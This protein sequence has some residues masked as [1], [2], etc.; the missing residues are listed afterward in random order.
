M[1]YFKYTIYSLVV[2]LA[3]I[4]GS[5]VKAVYPV[6]RRLRRLLQPGIGLMV[7]IVFTLFI[8]ATPA[9]GATEFV[10]V[11]DPAGGEGS[12]FS[13]LASWNTTVGCDLTA[14][15]TLVFTY[16]TSTVSG[17]IPN[18][19]EVTGATSGATSTAVHV[20]STTTPATH[21]ILMKE[22]GSGPFLNGEKVYIT[23]EGGGSSNYIYLSSTGTQAI[24]VA[25]CRNTGGSGTWDTSA[26]NLWSTYWTTDSDLYIKIWTDPDDDYSRHKGIWDDN[27]YKY[28]YT[29][30]GSWGGGFSIT[31]VD[32]EIEGLQ[33]ELNS[34]FNLSYHGI[35]EIGATINDFDHQ[36]SHNIIR[37]GSISTLT[38][39]GIY[40]HG[41]ANLKLF[42]NIIYGFN[43]TNSGAI[44][45]DSKASAGINTYVYNNTIYSNY[46]GIDLYNS[47]ASYNAAYNNL[48]ASNLADFYVGQS[49]WDDGSNNASTDG[50]ADFDPDFADYNN[51]YD[52]Q[53]FT[54]IDAT[55]KDFH[56]DP[57]DTGARQKGT[58]TVA[59]D[60]NMGL[61]DDIDGTPRSGAMDIGAD[62][63]ATEFI[64][65][66]CETSGSSGDC[67]E[68]DYSRLYDWEAAVDCDLT[69]SST[70]IF[71]GS[72]TGQLDE[73]DS[74]GL[75]VNGAAIA[76]GTVVATTT[77]QILIDNISGTTTL[78]IAASGS[79]WKVDASNYWTV[80]GSGDDLGASPIAVAK[81]D[82]TWDSADTQPF[83]ITDWT[84]D[85]DNY[86]RI[87]TTDTARHNAKWSNSSY[88][89]SGTSGNRII[90]VEES[91]VRLDGLQID[92]SGYGNGIQTGP[93][94]EILEDLRYSNNIIKG[95]TDTGR[96]IEFDTSYIV[97][98]KVWNNIMYN[99][100]G[101]SAEIIRSNQSDNI[102]YIYNNTFRNGNIGIRALQ[103]DIIA[104]NNLI[105][106]TTDPFSGTFDT[107]T[108]YN[109][110]DI[111][112][113][114]GEGSNNLTNQTFTF[115]STAS[116]TEDLHLHENDT[117]A[118]NKGTDLSSDDN[119]SFSD[120]IDGV[121]RNI[122][123]EGWDIG[124]D[125][126]ATKIYRSV[127]NDDSDLKN[128][129]NVT[130]SDNTATFSAAQPD[131]VGVGDVVQYGGSGYYE[132]AFITSR[133][134]STEYG[135]QAWDGS[136]PTATTSAD[137]SIY[138]AHLTL[139]DWE[140]HQVTDDD[141]NSSI[142]EDVDDLVI[143]NSQDLTASDTVMIV[144]CYGASNPDNE[145]VIING[146]TT[147]ARNYIKI[148]TPTDSNEVGVTQR[149]PGKWDADK[150][151]ME[152]ANTEMIRNNASNVRID[153]LQIYITESASTGYVMGIHNKDPVGVM[154][155]RVS[156]CIVRGCV[157][158]KASYFLGIASCSGGVLGSLKIWNNIVYNFT[159][160][161]T[162][163]A[164]YN[165]DPNGTDYVYNNTAFN[166]K[167]G[168]RQDG[169]TF[170]AINNISYNNTDNYSGSFDPA[171]TNNLSGP[172]QSDAPVGNAINSATVQF[173]DEV[174]YDLHLSPS[175]I[176]AI[177][178]GTS[179]VLSSWSAAI[180]SRDS[181]EYDIDNHLRRDWDIG[182]DDASVEFVSTVMQSGGDFS[183]LYTWEEANEVDLTATTTAVYSCSV[184]TG[185]I[186]VGAT[187]IGTSTGATA[188]TTL[189]ATSSSQIL[190]YN[191]T[192]SS[193]GS[194]FISGEKV[195]IEGG[196]TTSN[197][198]ILSNAGNPA[199]ATA[200]IDGTW[201]S[202]DEIAVTIDDW[203]TGEYNYIRIY[204]TDTARHQG[205]WDTNRYRIGPPP[206]DPFTSHINIIEDYTIIEGLQVT[207]Y[208]GAFRNGIYINADYCYISN[209]IIKGG[210]ND[211][212]GI[213]V[214]SGVLNLAYIWNNIIY[215]MGSYGIYELADSNALIYI[216]NNTIY[217]IPTGVI[218]YGSQSILINNI[219]NDC[220]IIGFDIDP[221]ADSDFNISSDG[222]A[223]GSN[224]QTNA[225]VTFVDEAN[226]DFHLDTTDT[227]AKDA[228]TYLYNDSNIRITDDIDGNSRN[229]ARFDIGA[230]EAP[231]IIYRSVGNDT[232]DLN[233][234]N[235]TTTI[236]STTATFSTDLPLN[237]GVGDALEYGSPLQIAFIVGR[238]SA[239][240]FEV[241]DWEGKMPTATTSQTVSIY[242]SHEHLN[243]WESHD[244]GGVNSSIDSAVDDYVFLFDT[245]LE[246]SNT[247]MYVPCYASTSPDDNSV[248]LNGWTTGTTSFVK[249]YTPNSSSEVGASQRHQGIWS[250]SAYRLVT[251]V[252]A[253]NASLWTN[254]D[255]LR[256]EGLQIYHQGSDSGQSAILLIGDGR[257]YVSKN[258]IRA[259]LTDDAAARGIGTHGNN[260]AINYFY[261]NIVYDFVNGTAESYGI[262]SGGSKDSYVYNN[263]VYNCY[264]GI[265]YSDGTLT[266][267]NNVVFNTSDDFVNPGSMTLDYN[268]SDDD[269]SGSDAHWVDMGS[270]TETWTAA[271]KDYANYDFRVRDTGSVLYKAG[272]VI[273]VV[274]D[275]IAGNSRPF[276]EQYDIGAF[277]LI[278]GDKFRLIPGQGTIKFR[279]NVKFK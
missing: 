2:F 168:F 225:S 155:F 194:E 233:T 93:D 195:Y 208:N 19:T 268:A 136:V 265:A 266:A 78:I 164:F 262:I 240:S 64:S 264:Q 65:T 33:I 276:N 80:T 211:Q 62:E 186:P 41:E 203:T 43:T 260:D 207:P 133:A 235:A 74:I 125:E 69:A 251:T 206:S 142:D 129:A 35:I 250:D 13:S 215:N 199:I 68:M 102:I 40:D 83:Y 212:T 31:N 279:G 272:T 105:S 101:S 4:V 44:L 174:N 94:N 175:D 259:T 107:G 210:G 112:D 110:T 219:T 146:W 261:N 38:K 56:L 34:A 224:S 37:A 148:Y 124:A 97:K 239:D 3:M 176:S 106:S 151:R 200:K 71:S 88:R 184:A 150:Y 85:I 122:D 222:S 149:H 39:W 51:G 18:G 231:T 220:S 234:V 111:D 139:D 91:A 143:T 167:I 98:A 238:N 121:A 205:K 197:Y 103:G 165:A 140:D 172:T 183:T 128:A 82:G 245:N 190:L 79:I 188:S 173:V 178:A 109:A 123:E 226:D 274:T 243:Y 36:I 116:G 21:Q 113:T 209:N 6:A 11:V 95:D 223:P 29:N 246:A 100:L 131:N 248:Q 159:G 179:S 277:E 134:S 204:T 15:T 47:S 214:A 163:A 232:R 61:V 55:N 84:T 72:I 241:E 160:I 192:A 26:V 45:I 5:Q 126:A 182:A 117:G 255:F 198:C 237:I 216:Y 66:I 127:G 193:S 7:S 278:V 236:A 191:I 86:I 52:N 217:N 67:T 196:A 252:V 156:N 213:S 49:Y 28:K 180:G 10:A 81:I 270:S 42:N 229:I 147:G 166:N 50:S 120:D 263:T 32:L 20:T 90:R 247:A 108:D 114:P 162:S 137:F 144:A 169:G 77:D 104:I 27:K 12:D 218:S 170:V 70:R 257:Y 154:D 158:T 254:I 118:R 202:A 138:R 24:A 230:D 130:I 171:S 221:H 87:Y 227:I 185:S 153:G 59:I 253:G 25:K 189:M 54:F 244:L 228:G 135:V 119:I 275:D 145:S 57:D 22:I 58:T 63:I 14:A 249:I 30:A 256:Y 181:I 115:I 152:G 23:S 161:N 201:S 73:N 53:T 76:T 1:K 16:T 92:A 242:R 46:F 267:K 48:L 177:D 132:L 8:F 99:I 60:A 157:N 9:I 17:A 273:S 75:Y 258:I 96:A 269:E 187:V 89:L 141:V 271:F